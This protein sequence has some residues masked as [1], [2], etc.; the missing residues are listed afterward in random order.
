[1]SETGSWIL[2]D[3]DWE[4]VITASITSFIESTCAFN[5]SSLKTKMK[6]KAKS[7]RSPKLSSYDNRKTID[8]GVLLGH[9]VQI[10]QI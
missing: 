5:C 9:R 1:M 4:K 7:S 6:Y 10:R 8:M 2:F 3:H